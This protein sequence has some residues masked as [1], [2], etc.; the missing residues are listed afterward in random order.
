MIESWGFYV[1]AGKASRDDTSLTP[2]EAQE[3]YDRYLRLWES[4]E[5]FGFDGLAFAEHHFNP[6]NLSPSPH[7]IIAS[8]AAR[9]RKLRFTT[10]GSVLPLHDARR[11]AEETGM[12]DYLTR[13]R[14]EPGIAPG[15]GDREAVMAGVPSAEVRPR[16]YSGAEVLEKA[17]AGPRVTHHDDFYD[18][19]EVPIMPP[20]REGTGRTV[21]V[22]ATSPE[23]AAW[24]AERGYKM[25]TA[26]LPTPAADALAARYREAAGKAGRTGDPAMLGIRRRV[27]VADSD[28]E[29]QEKV[30][31]AAD[32]VAGIIGQGFETADPK[33]RAMMNHPDDSAI[34]SPATVAEKLVEQCRSGGY[35]A[36]MHFTDFAGFT[37]AD[38]TRSH[39]LI[40]H[41]VAP[42]LR[43]ADVKAP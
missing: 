42:V 6:V 27:F 28:A 31:A 2:A 15:A 8:L 32:H 24:T 25:C 23:S 5:D 21:W 14:F 35:G 43:S 33:I 34:G 7:L 19:D 30:E 39:E 36:I 26:W 9:T 37:P 1:F 11:Y 38:L 3:K 13:G 17:L 18:L 16:Y 12:L 20:V 10:L 41:R 22:T 40:G 29:A 4:C